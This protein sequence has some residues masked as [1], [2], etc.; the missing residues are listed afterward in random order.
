MTDPSTVGVIGASSLV[1]R[2]VIPLL[3]TAGHPVVAFSRMFRNQHPV[4]GISWRQL[5]APD[6]DPVAATAIEVWLCLAPI[7]VLPQYFDTIAAHGA[8]RVVA[9]SST[10]RFTKVGSSESA[11]S[12][13]AAL[14]AKGEADL[15][16]WA[17]ANQV[18]WVILRPTLIYGM[19]Q[20]K[21]LTEIARFV[22]RFSFFPLIANATGLRQ[23]IHVQDAAA[24]CAAALVTPVA[25]NREYNIAGR[26]ALPYKEM[27]RRIFLAAGLHPR[28][29]TIPLFVF[30]VALA[31]LR[32]LPKYRSWSVAMAERMQKDM[33]FDCSD[34]ARDLGFSPR[35]FSFGPEDFPQ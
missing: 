32:V 34:A 24:V 17:A 9:L 3:A 25:A 10:S 8:R 5:V 35:V 18:E 16:T 6:A 4:V 14:L 2:C 1:G 12:A 27:V 19:G 30:R 11:D 31:C 13:V 28:L 20:D 23:P 33:V 26:D 22:R 21:N 15:K 29:V 7:W